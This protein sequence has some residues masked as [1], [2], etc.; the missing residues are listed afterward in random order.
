MITRRVRNITTARDNMSSA[1]DNMSLPA[2]MIRGPDRV[3]GWSGP[4]QE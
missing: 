2:R 4:R 1:F 3:I